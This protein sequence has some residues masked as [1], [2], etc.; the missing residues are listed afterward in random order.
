MNVLENRKHTIVHEKT[1]Q[2]MANDSNKINE[3]K[4]LIK[5]ELDTCSSRMWPHVCQLKQTPEGYKRIEDMVIR[6]V[7][8]E[9]ML[10]GSAIA[11]IE[12]EF[13]H[14]D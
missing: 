10:V 6:L 5:I 9:A 8:K 2:E 7:A 11:L 4:Q 3:L 12:Q 13:S 1:M 14:L